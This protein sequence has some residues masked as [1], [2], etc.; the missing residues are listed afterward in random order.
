MSTI[1]SH[2]ER[3]ETNIVKY[4]QLRK[5]GEGDLGVLC[6]VYANF[7]SLKLLQSKL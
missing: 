4:K 1:Y 2:R 3:D 7:I 5:Q 6:I